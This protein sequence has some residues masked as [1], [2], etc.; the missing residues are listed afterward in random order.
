MHGTKL[1]GITGHVEHPLCG[2]KKKCRLPVARVAGKTRRWGARRVEQPK[3][4]NP[5]RRVLYRYLPA[6]DALEGAIMDF[7]WD[8]RTTN[9]ALAPVAVIVMDQSHGCGQGDLAAG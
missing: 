7:D 8:A 9:L 5:G 6:D 3:G 1:F 4:I 2:S